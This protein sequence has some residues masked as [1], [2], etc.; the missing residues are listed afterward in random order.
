M[1]SIKSSNFNASR[2]AL[3]L[4]ERYLQT[5]KRFRQL[6]FGPF[7]SAAWIAFENKFLA[8]GQTARYAT[9]PVVPPMPQGHRPGQWQS[10]KWFSKALLHISLAY[11][12]LVNPAQISS[13]VSPGAHRQGPFKSNF[14]VR[15]RPSPT[16]L[17]KRNLK[18]AAGKKKRVYPFFFKKPG[19]IQFR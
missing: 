18:A 14:G 8:G 5:A 6:P 1:V 16:S 3:P 11:V 13:P 7:A 2:L 12:L 9:V 17:Q 19:Q 10:R 15:Y 4:S